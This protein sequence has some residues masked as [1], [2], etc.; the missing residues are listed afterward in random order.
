VYFNEIIR[1][2]K[3]GKEWEGR[4]VKNEFTFSTP[5]LG[6]EKSIHLEG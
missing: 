6:E 1:W 4:S 2:G 3:K 5:Q